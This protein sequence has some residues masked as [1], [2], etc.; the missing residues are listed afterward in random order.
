[1]VEH[2]AQ[3]NQG[4]ELERLLP[5]FEQHADA[6]KDVHHS[7]PYGPDP[8]GKWLNLLIGSHATLFYKSH[9]QLELMQA[10]H[11]VDSVSQLRAVAQIDAHAFATLDELVNPRYARWLDMNMG[12]I[13]RAVNGRDDNW[14]LGR[15]TPKGGYADLQAHRYREGMSETVR[16]YWVAARTAASMDVMSER[17]Y[18]LVKSVVTEHSIECVKQGADI[19]GLPSEVMPR[20]LSTFAKLFP[21]R[22][23]GMLAN[24]PSEIIDEWASNPDNIDGLYEAQ[25]QLEELP[26]VFDISLR[27]YILGRASGYDQIF[28]WDR[29]HARI[30]RL[31]KFFSP[32]QQHEKAAN[33]WFNRQFEETQIDE[34]QIQRVAEFLT[35]EEIEQLAH[36]G[37]QTAEEYRQ[38]VAN[39]KEY[40]Q[41]REGHV[42]PEA[43]KHRDPGTKVVVLP[44][45]APLDLDNTGRNTVTL[46]ALE[47]LSGVT[48]HSYV[49][50]RSH[51]RNA[52]QEYAEANV[53][54]AYVDPKHHERAS[55]NEYIDRF[56]I[57]DLSEETVIAMFGLNAEDH[58]DAE[59]V[60]WSGRQ[61]RLNDDKLAELIR[62]RTGKYPH[63]MYAQMPIDPLEGSECWRIRE[64]VPF[65]P[66]PVRPTLHDVVAQT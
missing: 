48:E 16:L 11:G 12:A 17:S 36:V 2:E 8:D 4:G 7:I 59:I 33:V 3:A 27:Q 25:A 50:S 53:E 32:E 6:F 39:Y 55:E 30:D 13:D 40:K 61:C 64:Y 58:G 47:V 28:S 35:Q 44:I 57:E 46:S 43:L 56:K 31:D 34:S 45:A 42:Y 62:E 26:A 22:A 38:A 24:D 41:L 1:M 60:M 21:G 19:L 18:G 65:Q 66:E 37:Q 15:N 10:I 5:L 49:T 14:G 52:R 29:L 9:D 54:V 20:M 51:G 23:L 63:I